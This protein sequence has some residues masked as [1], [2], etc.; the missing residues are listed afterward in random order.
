MWRTDQQKLAAIALLRRRG[1]KPQPL[2]RIYIRKK[3]GQWRPL[4]I[5]TILDRA[6]R[7]RRIFG[8]RVMPGNIVAEERESYQ[9]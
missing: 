9:W 5:P 3:N 8:D 1:Y 7:R 4:S 6:F 2:R